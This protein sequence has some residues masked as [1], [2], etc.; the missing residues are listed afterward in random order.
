VNIGFVGLRISKNFSTGSLRKKSWQGSSKQA[1]VRE[2][3]VLGGRGGSTLGILGGG[4]ETMESTD[5]R[6]GLRLD[7]WT[8]KLTRRLSKSSPP[9]WISP[10]VPA[11]LVAWHCRSLKYAGMATTALVMV[12]LR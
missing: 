12:L 10:A 8:K 4:T 6:G 1:R 11:S 5:V 9:R 7:S 2:Y 3:R